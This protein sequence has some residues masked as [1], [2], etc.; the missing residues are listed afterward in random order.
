MNF[1]TDPSPSHHTIVSIFAG[2]TKRIISF[3]LLFLSFLLLMM[4]ENFVISCPG[5]YN[6]VYSNFIKSRNTVVPNLEKH[7]LMDKYL[8]T[9]CSDVSNVRYIFND[10][11]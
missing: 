10:S 3:V 9:C 8:L 5:I 1:V 6:L 7:F 4:L 11:N 2:H